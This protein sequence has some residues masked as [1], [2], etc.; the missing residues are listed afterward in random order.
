VRNS[1]ATPPHL[2]VVSP[3]EGA[4]VSPGRLEFR[5]QG[6]PSAAYYEVHLVT[7]DGNVVWLGKADGTSLRPPPGITLEA[8]QK[9]FVW[10]LAYLS[11][12]GTIKSAAVPF[13]V[14]GS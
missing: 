11:G 3:A 5:W 2:G 9:Y 12:G 14:G 6:I 13:F 7:S 10:I 4:T 8:G 1:S